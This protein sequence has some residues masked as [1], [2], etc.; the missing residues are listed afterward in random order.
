MANQPTPL[1]NMG[2]LSINY[3]YQTFLSGGV[4]WQAMMVA[5]R[6]ML[7][8]A[9]G[10]AMVLTPPQ[11]TSTPLASRNSQ[12]GQLRPPL[13]WHVEASTPRADPHWTMWR[14][15][16][17]LVRVVLWIYK[18]IGRC[19]SVL[20][21]VIEIW[22][23]GKPCFVLIVLICCSLMTKLMQKAE[24][25]FDL[26]GHM[27]LWWC[28]GNGQYLLSGSSALAMEKYSF[29]VLETVAVEEKWIPASAGRYSDEC[30]PNGNE[31]TKGSE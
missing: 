16:L 23:E 10:G 8:D 29:W 17:Q 21:C 9:L 30:A 22:N 12:Q 20:Q 1:K 14:V 2:L 25:H 18:C 13:I 6:I 31:F 19:T 27:V 4:R 3:M 5:L 26:Y 28:P 15:G 11:C 24:N 7:H